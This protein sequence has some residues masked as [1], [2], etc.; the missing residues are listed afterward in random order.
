MISKGY[1]SVTIYFLKNK[2]RI[3]SACIHEYKDLAAPKLQN[4]VLE[5]DFVL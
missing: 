4:F 2:C 1:F 3:I 5:I